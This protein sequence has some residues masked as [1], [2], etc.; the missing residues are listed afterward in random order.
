M[1]A[2]SLQTDQDQEKLTYLERR[3]DEVANLHADVLRHWQ[4]A[5]E[6]GTKKLFCAVQTARHFGKL[7][8]IK[9]NYTSLI[10]Y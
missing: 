3:G 1:G 10:N 6:G 8:L 9:V 7:S 2:L 4:Q 5:K